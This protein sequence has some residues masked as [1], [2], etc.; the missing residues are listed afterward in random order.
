MFHTT[1]YLLLRGI[2]D[3]PQ[4]EESFEIVDSARYNN[5]RIIEI[6]RRCVKDSP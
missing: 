1:R 6:V 4:R 3:I 5:N 2:V